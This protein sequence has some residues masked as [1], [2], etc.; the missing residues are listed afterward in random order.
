ML[1]I[2][3][4]SLPHAIYAVDF[5]LIFISLVLIPEF[6]EC[7]ME[8]YID[9]VRHPLATILTMR[10]MHNTMNSMRLFAPILL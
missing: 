5:Y 9:V 8:F 10:S 2:S 3:L 6:I 1:G 4:H 7:F